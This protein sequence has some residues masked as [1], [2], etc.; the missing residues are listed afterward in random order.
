MFKKAL[1]ALSIAAVSAASAVAQAQPVSDYKK[2]EFFA[3]YSNGQVDTGVDSG[4]SAVDFFRDRDNFNGVNGSGVY[5]FSRYF[6]V[7]G[8]VSATYNNKSISG[9]TGGANVSFKT[10]NSLY[11]FLGGVQAKDNS[12]EGVFKPFGHVLVGA[13]HA[14]T[15]FKDYTCTPT[16]GV[17]PTVIVPDATFSETGFAA[18]IGGGIDFRVSDRFQVRAIQIDWNPVRIAGQTQNNLRLGAGIVF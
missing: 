11:N 17:C 1:I 5:N 10:N 3:G 6:G 16:T 2:V 15:N 9:E 12:N 13:A 4:N 18:A 8:D 7:K 14:R